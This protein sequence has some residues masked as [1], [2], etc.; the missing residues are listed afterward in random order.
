MSTIHRI[1]CGTHLHADNVLVGD[2][3]PLV[4][5]T[6]LLHDGSIYEHESASIDLGV[7]DH[8]MKPR[9]MSAGNGTTYRQGGSCP[10]YCLCRKLNARRETS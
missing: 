3:V 7:I 1:W 10:A 9:F 6:Y 5:G 8:Y 4:D 2:L